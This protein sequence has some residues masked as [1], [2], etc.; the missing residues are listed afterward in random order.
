[1]KDNI[2]LTNNVI[3]LYLY[4]DAHNKIIAANE[5]INEP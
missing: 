2:V 4:V 5:N 3:I 1:M